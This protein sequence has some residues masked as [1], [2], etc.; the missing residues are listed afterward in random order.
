MAS[1]NIQRSQFCTVVFQ[2][3][4]VTVLCDDMYNTMYTGVPRVNTTITS[5][6]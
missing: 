5:Y 1:Q 2:A 4:F 3:T 6:N